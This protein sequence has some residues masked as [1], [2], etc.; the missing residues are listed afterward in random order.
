[1]N[2]ETLSI[3]DQPPL[4]NSEGGDPPLSQQQ[5]ETPSNYLLV[6]QDQQNCNDI[7]N[8]ELDALFNTALQE[9]EVK[10]TDLEKEIDQLLKRKVQIEEDTKKTFTG[11]SDDIARRVRGF[12]EYHSDMMHQS[13]CNP[14]SLVI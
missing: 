7:N 9:L 5:L 1:M 8:K 10:K 11:Q 14:Q 4:K 6:S 12:Q 3:K 2:E 13:C